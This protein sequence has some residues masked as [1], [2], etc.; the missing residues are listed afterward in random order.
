MRSEWGLWMSQA[1]A[2]DAVAYER[3][4]RALVPMLERFVRARLHDQQAAEDV[5]QNI[6]LALHRAR[7]TYRPERPF[8]PWI[9]AIARNSVIDSLRKQKVRRRFEQ[10]LDGVPDPSQDTPIGPEPDSISPE[11]ARAL[12]QLPAAQREAVELVKLHGLSMQE[13]AER[14]GTTAGALK[15]RAHRGY[16]KL[17]G[18]LEEMRTDP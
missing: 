11:L 10:S 6:L 17:R 12:A 16:R 7:H 5:V 18:L 14:A 8:Q 1:Q 9:F 15:V 3:L 4:L 2:G 13:A